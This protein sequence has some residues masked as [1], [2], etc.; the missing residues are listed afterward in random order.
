M[1]NIPAELRFAKSHEWARLE[2][3]GTVTVGISDHAQEALGDVVFV[4]LPEIGKVFAAGDTAGVVE[5]VKAASD[6]YSPVAG[7][8]I[9]IN[10]ELSG[11]PELLN[12][13]PYSAWIF[14]LK[15]SDAN[16]DLAKLLDA[17]G[18]KSVISE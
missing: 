11:S 4:E 9:E 1:S 6:I 8:V 5:S 3:D 18:Y 7:E 14:K 2:S 17:D 13:E 15:P 10:E 12:S 16:G